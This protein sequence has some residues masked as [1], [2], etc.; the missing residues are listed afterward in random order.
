MSYV[1]IL[2][3][4]FELFLTSAIWGLMCGYER[5]VV[6]GVC[7]VKLCWQPVTLTPEPCLCLHTIVVLFRLTPV[8]IH[9]CGRRNG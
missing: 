4:L 2:L 6:L 7:W 1:L 5:S 8:C 3:A 9:F